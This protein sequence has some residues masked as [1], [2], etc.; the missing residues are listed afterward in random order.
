MKNKRSDTLKGWP[1][2]LL[3]GL[4]AAV[5]GTQ[6]FVAPY[7]GL[8]NNGD[9]GKVCARFALAPHGGWSGNFLY[10]VPDYEFHPQNYWR[11]DVV[12][13]EILLAAVPILVSRPSGH[14]NIR[15]VGAVHAALFLAAYCLLLVYLRRFRPLVRI[16]SAL[17][18][19]FVL[20]DAV[21]IAYFN[22]FYSDT[23]AMLGILLSVPLA[24]LLGGAKK[25]CVA[26]SVVFG[27]SALL[28]ITSKAQH[29]I[30]ALLPVLFLWSA[31]R[32][33]RRARIAAVCG[34]V[35]LLGAA[36]IVLAITPRSYSA[37]ALYNLIF[38]KLAPASASPQSDL[39]ELGLSASDFRYIG[40]YAFLDGNPTTDQVWLADF[41]RRTSYGAVLRFYLRHPSRPLQ[42]LLSD[43]RAEA[44]QMR[45][46]N[47]S[48]FRQQD[49]H[50]PGARTTRFALW[51][52][53][54]S[55]MFRWA[56]FHVAI[57]YLLLVPVA[58][59]LAFRAASP[60]A[61]SAAVI[62]VGIAV[63]AVAEFGVA[64]LTDACETYRHLLLFHLLTDITFCFAVVWALQRAF[65]GGV[66]RLG[67]LPPL[68]VAAPTPS[69]RDR[70]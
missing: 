37:Q 14:F 62:C 7:I 9:F 56:P 65:G 5:L 64:S 25:P 30:F 43:L 34:G 39:L 10:F 29:G 45:P 33:D 59:R 50:P 48:N 63:M 54:R 36:A 52:S 69:R 51:S 23:A 16:A 27:L 47:L 38:Y 40:T 20:G 17:G 53:L 6:L 4:A 49:G 24:L 60:Q 11:S 26:L 32:G 2:A 22:S 15:G 68:F 12:S 55:R 35:V 3:A 28:W 21:Y 41:N 31:C 1:E 42:F 58:L 18:V 70:A 61:R 19:L 13:S 57:W 67:G 46:E 66:I 44:W 8:A